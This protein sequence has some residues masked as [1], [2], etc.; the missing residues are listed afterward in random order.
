MV[1]DWDTME[2][3]PFPHFKGGEGTVY[4]KMYFDGMN[5]LLMARLAPGASIGLHTHDTS[6]EIIHVLGGRARIIMDGAEEIV[7][8]GQVHYCAKG[9]SHTT[10]SAG[11]EDLVMLAIVP[12]Q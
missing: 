7:L 9:H 3:K 2:E 10:I 12:E 4:G 6:S 8:P 11:E 5:R 1:L